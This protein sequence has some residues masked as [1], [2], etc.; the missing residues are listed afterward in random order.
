MKD[1]DFKTYD[2]IV[3]NKMIR[4]SIDNF[5]EKDIDCSDR[6]L[7]V[8]KYRTS[9]A[10][11]IPPYGMWIAAIK[12]YP[13]LIN[14]LFSVGFQFDRVNWLKWP[15]V[16]RSFIQQGWHFSLS[17][18]FQVIYDDYQDRFNCSRECNFLYERVRGR[19]YLSIYDCLISSIR[20]R[21]YSNSAI[22]FLYDGMDNGSDNVLESINIDYKR[23]PHLDLRDEKLLLWSH[24]LSLNL[25][26]WFINNKLNEENTF[27]LYA[28]GSRIRLR[29][30]TQ[31]GVNQ[32]ENTGSLRGEHWYARGN[33]L[34]QYDSKLEEALFLL[35]DLINF[36]A[37]EKEFQF[38]FENNPRFLLLLGNYKK[39][40]PQLILSEDSG[41]RLIP[42]FFLEKIDSDF[43][44]ILDLKRPCFDLIKYQKNRIKFREAIMEAIAQLNYYRDWFDDKRNREQFRKL[45]GLNSYKPH[46]VVVVGRRAS[47]Y[48]EITRIK[49]ETALPKW[50]NLTTYDD[51]I[52]RVKQ[53]KQFSSTG[54]I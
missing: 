34:E 15:K 9:D 18:F 25:E 11:A 43:C 35:E 37:K 28:E 3:L 23:A 44:D 41:A 48:D 38:F 17:N 14:F 31:F 24:N 52:D 2:D 22:E 40:H 8:F 1:F 36:N 45:Y 47:Y 21:P 7:E 26:N 42:D 4:N 12:H 49:L 33:V 20:A 32:L 51:I 10:C 30:F 53:W 19:G 50:V 6:L 54:F 5:F 27:L 46:V 16:E 39:L 29:P 13:Q